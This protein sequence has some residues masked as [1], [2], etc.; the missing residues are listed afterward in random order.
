MG[1]CQSLEFDGIRLVNCLGYNFY[2]Y[3]AIEFLC[4]PL[5]IYD[6]M[7]GITTTPE[8]TML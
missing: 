1:V 6:V 4:I 7:Y 5:S 8:G 2:I 3:G